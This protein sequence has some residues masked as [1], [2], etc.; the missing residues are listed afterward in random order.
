MEPMRSRRPAAWGARQ[1]PSAGPRGPFTGDEYAGCRARRLGGRLRRREERR[2]ELPR[3]VVGE[4]AA[5][6]SGVRVGPA[7]WGE[8]H[9]LAVGVEAEDGAEPGADERGRVVRELAVQA[10]AVRHEAD[11]SLG[12]EQPYHVEHEEEHGL[13]LQRLV[14][15]VLE[16]PEPGAEVGEDRGEGDRDRLGRQRLDVVLAVQHGRAAKVDTVP[17]PPTMPNLSISGSN[18]RTREYKPGAGEGHAR[19][20]PFVVVAHLRYW[21]D[22]PRR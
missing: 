7:V 13:A 19:F 18:V 3:R 8:E 9:P 17:R 5:S 11:H 16:R 10:Q 4:P 22:L 21:P 1:V 2:V 20:A 12:D 6:G 14:L 15:P